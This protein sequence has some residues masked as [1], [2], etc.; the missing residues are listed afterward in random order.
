METIDDLEA[1]D[2]LQTLGLEYIDGIYQSIEISSPIVNQMAK[3][4][5]LYLTETDLFENPIINYVDHIRINDSM[6][7]NNLA[8]ISTEDEILDYLKSFC[9]TTMYLWD[10]EKKL[11]FYIK[12]F[13]NDKV[14]DLLQSLDRFIVWEY[15][16]GNILV[17]I[18]LDDRTWKEKMGEFQLFIKNYIKNPNFKIPFVKWISK[19]LNVCLPKMNLDPGDTT[20][21]PSD[22]YL[23]NIL[24]LLFA[25]WEEG[26][27]D[28]RLSSIDYNYIISKQ[29]SMKWFDK[30]D[31]DL[32]KEYNF[33]TMCFFLILNTLR[34]GY[35]PALYRKKNWKD[36]LISFEEELNALPPLF[37]NVFE[38]ESAYVIKNVK[39]YV[40]I[41]TGIASNMA[42][43]QSIQKFYSQVI[44]FIIKNKEN[45]LNDIYVDMVYYYNNTSNYDPR[46]MSNDMYQLFLNIMETDEYTTNITI[47][48]DFM[49]A[50]YRIF[51]SIPALE[52]NM[53]MKIY[54]SF[55][56][57]LL[58]LHEKI[59]TSHIREDFKITK[60]LTIYNKLSSLYIK[61]CSTFLDMF[62]IQML[63]N[64]D[65]T[66]KFFMTLL[67]DI[68]EYY[69]TAQY[70]FDKYFQDKKTYV[71]TLLS[72]L[73]H[74][75]KL[76][77]FI[78]NL[79]MTFSTNELWNMFMTKEVLMTIST[80]VNES[81]KILL[82]C[83][84]VFKDSE[85][86]ISES[87]TFRSTVENIINTLEKE[88]KITSFIVNDFSF[89]IEI[90]ENLKIDP[91]YDNL[92]KYIGELENKDDIDMSD[93]PMEFL[94]PIMYCPIEEPCMLPD[95]IGFS[96]E[97]F[98]D[99]TIMMKQ[100]LL[101][102]ENPFTR[103]KLS[104]S[105]L[106]NFNEQPEIKE[107]NKDFIDRQTAWK[108]N[109]RNNP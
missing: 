3:L 46:Y 50:L 94:D 68:C 93:M 108:N 1:I 48:C 27:N 41:D 35:I 100:L 103:S 45:Q 24:G 83:D 23:A 67:T 51:S 57:T 61:K 42:L 88:N 63:S 7:W 65:I 26:I 102:E 55:S 75:L 109:K 99:K 12:I 84:G 36:I 95:M 10:N 78:D 40:A 19:V 11:E 72:V 37:R 18:H 6:L 58:I 62:K 47:K 80:V 70:Y 76:L 89:D 32:D 69:S 34:V 2:A 104:I 85:L 82:K 8:N 77:N 15:T 22:L 13:K 29:C 90:Y 39:D 91:L 56:K 81:A 106:E 52:K 92:V 59:N 79:L 49:T 44:K 33:L 66:K 71:S 38:K 25:F 60:K 74:C 96:D 107:K 105:D 28:N 86:A 9:L 21:M 5:K 98:F 73:D 17:T 30:K 101:K 87:H 53:D 16:F 43:N 97:K 64:K 14:N 54:E 20:A 31:N 4:E